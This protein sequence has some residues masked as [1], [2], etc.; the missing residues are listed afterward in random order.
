MHEDPGLD[1]SR[2]AATL[3]A[4]YN[5]AVASVTF[6]PL[7]LDDRA[8]VY[9]VVCVDG[10]SRFLKVTI[11]P[12]RLPGLLVPSALVERGVPNILAA[13][14]TGSGELCC[15]LDGDL[16][17]SLVLFPFIRGGSAKVVGMSDKQWRTFGRTVQAVHDSSLV[18]QF[19]GL[20]GTETFAL[21]SAAK[22]RR[23]FDFVAGA[24]FESPAAIRL[25]AWWLEN[26]AQI[27]HLLERAEELGRLLQSRWFELVLCHGDIHAA[28]ILVAVDGRIFLSDWDGPPEPLIAPRE[29]DLLF[30]VGSR[31][32]RPVLP[33]EEDLFF[34]GYGSVTIDRDVLVYFRYER[35]VQDI[36]EY[37]ESVFLNE[38]LPED[39]RAE[40][41]AAIVA[42]FEPG[43]V[44]AVAE[45]VDDHDRSGA[46]D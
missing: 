18:E 38:D 8:A 13:V 19:R 42:F 17:V 16:S 4:H 41:A 6:L 29:R 9:E 36:G 43:G 10:T 35:I 44:A 27:R 40:D 24:Q 26:T 39:A 1:P 2:I 5:L 32:A 37:G 20:L 7:S 33:R 3:D 11:G 31:I 14:R 30:V 12:A 15:P 28:N 34:E 25:A 45:I 46:S 23:L 21:P 22:V